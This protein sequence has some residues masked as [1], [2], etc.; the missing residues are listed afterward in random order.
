[1]PETN[2]SLREEKQTNY[3]NISNTELYDVLLHNRDVSYTIPNL[4]DW[5]SK[6]GLY[7]NAFSHFISKATL[8]LHYVIANEL[9]L[10]RISHM[11]STR[12]QQAMAELIHGNAMQHT[13]CTSKLPVSEAVLDDP[14]N[15]LYIYGS[16]MFFRE[17]LLNKSNYIAFDGNKTYFAVQLNEI[18]LSPRHIDPKTSIDDLKINPSSERMITLAWLV[19]D[20]KLFMVNSLLNSNKG[21]GVLA[22]LSEFKRYMHSNASNTDLLQVAKMFYAETKDTGVFLLRKQYVNP[23]P[24]TGFLS[25][26]QTKSIIM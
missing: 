9:V 16:P 8:N 18:F 22:M 14:L 1:M 24:K 26:F 3:H 13:V 17:A 11:L 20:F 10:K 23:F 2:W 19:N 21:N 5:V 25:L 6:A 12:Q 15:N 7:L 4:F